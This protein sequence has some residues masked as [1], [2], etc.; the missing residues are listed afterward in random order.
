MHGL[1]SL[2]LCHVGGH[3]SI[4]GCLRARGRRAYAR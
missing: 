3:C 2:D 1:H 4:H